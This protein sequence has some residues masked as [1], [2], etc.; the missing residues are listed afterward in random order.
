[1]GVFT[2]KNV[3]SAREEMRLLD[4]IEQYG[5]GNWEDI[6]KHIE[7]RT[8]EGKLF[9]NLFKYLRY[10]KKKKKKKNYFSFPI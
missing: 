3:W 5:F 2:G 4:A 6:A 10:Q 8:P 7:T 1:M 9:L